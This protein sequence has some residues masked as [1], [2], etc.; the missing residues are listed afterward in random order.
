MGTDGHDRA[1]LGVADVDDER[2]REMVAAQLGRS[3]TDVELVSS[4]AEPVAYDL[5]SITTA[6][7]CRVRG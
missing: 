6:C 4:S 2:L 5:D 1:A 3:P 7:R